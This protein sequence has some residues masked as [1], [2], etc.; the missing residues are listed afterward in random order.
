MMIGEGLVKGCCVPLLQAMA[1]Q[2]FN[3]STLKALAAALSQLPV[4]RSDCV[5]ATDEE[6]WYNDTM[7]TSS[8]ETAGAG[9]HFIERT[10]AHY[11]R[12]DMTSTYLLYR[13]CFEQLREAPDE[14]LP[15]S[16]DLT[17]TN[18]FGALRKYRA[19][20]SY[21]NSLRVTTALLTYHQDKHAWP[22]T[23]DAL[24]PDYLAAIPNDPTTLGG[25]F[26]YSLYEGRPRLVSKS[27]LWGMVGPQKTL[28]HITFYP[29]E[30]PYR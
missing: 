6:F 23:L 8:D 7:L 24:K 28:D 5:Q 26:D 29:Y 22:A 1:R 27:A 17:W 9:Q 19:A 30:D 14:G 18:L 4:T 12:G 16:D 2:G 20:L 11:L 13:P 10:V 21:L 25:G 15:V 3:S